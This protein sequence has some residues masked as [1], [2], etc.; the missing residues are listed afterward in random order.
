[1][2]VHMLQYGPATERLFSTWAMGFNK[3]SEEVM[4][5]ALSVEG[6]LTL[7]ELEN[8]LESGQSF[9]LRLL[10]GLEKNRHA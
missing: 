1:M 9:V 7:S 8:V 5:E 3:I 2:D 6:V 10:S 4:D